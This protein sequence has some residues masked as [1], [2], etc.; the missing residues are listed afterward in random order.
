VLP[1]VRDDSLPQAEE[2][3]YLWNSFTSDGWL[4]REMDRRIGASSA[5]MMALLRSIVV[6]MELSWKAKVSVHCS[7]FVPTLTY[8]HEIW[9]ETKRTRSRIQAADMRFLQRGAELSLRGRGRR[10]SRCS[11]ASQR[12][13]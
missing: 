6:K 11:A 8:G 5:M 10:S 1:P 13:S 12:V 9:V 2:F 7:I 4:E 3:K